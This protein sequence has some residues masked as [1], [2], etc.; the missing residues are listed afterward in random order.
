MHFS[1]LLRSI[2]RKRMETI[3]HRRTTKRFQ[4]GS[5]D[6]SLESGSYLGPRVPQRAYDRDIHKRHQHGYSRGE[7]N[8]RATSDSDRSLPLSNWLHRNFLRNLHSRLLQRH[9]RPICQLSGR[10]QSLPVQQER[11]ELRDQ[12]IRSGQM[13]LP[14]GLHGTVLSRQ[15]RR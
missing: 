13:P 14:T 12:Q 6:R 15:R 10:V 4:N 3:D 8:R 11:G 2:E 1:D 9:Q 5:H 7:S